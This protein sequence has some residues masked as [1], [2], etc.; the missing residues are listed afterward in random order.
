MGAVNSFGTDLCYQFDT[1]HQ[2]YQGIVKW[3]DEKKGFGFIQCQELA[4]DVFVHYT[5]IES[6]GFKTLKPGQ[7]VDFC[8]SR[9]A[10]GLQTLKLVVVNNQP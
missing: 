7:L 9:F 5:T 3:F 10:R 1:E 8:V 2:S 6:Q 4:E